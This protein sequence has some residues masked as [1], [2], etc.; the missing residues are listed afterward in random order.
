MGSGQAMFFSRSF[1][2]V[3]SDAQTLSVET[4]WDA[5]EDLCILSPGRLPKPRLIPLSTPGNFQVIGEV[6]AIVV[7]EETMKPCSF[8]VFVGDGRF[9]LFS[10]EAGQPF[11]VIGNWLSFTVVGLKLYDEGY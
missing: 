8:E 6:Q 5:V 7:D 4:A 11:P 3:S 1:P 10:E 2:R 9:S